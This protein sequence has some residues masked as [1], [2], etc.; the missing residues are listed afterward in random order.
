VRG[1]AGIGKTRLIEECQRRAEVL[2]FRSHTGQKFFGGLAELS[3]ASI[4]LGNALREL[5]AEFER[6][7]ASHPSQVPVIA[8]TG[9]E[10]MK[11]RYGVNYKPL[12]ELVKWID[13]P[14]E[15][16]DTSPV[17]LSEIWQDASARTG[18]PQ[19]THVPPPPPAALAPFAPATI[20][21]TT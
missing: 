18:R 19:A 12:L 16:P 20:G 17:E 8:C 13:R 5:Y 10:P 3:S 9:S 21:T 6:E 11:D 7:R 2:N 15:L 14:S 1:E 4:H